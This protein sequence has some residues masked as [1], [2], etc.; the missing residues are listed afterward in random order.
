MYDCKNNLL[1][2]HH[3]GPYI[4]DA[5]YYRPYII[6]N[7]FTWDAVALIGRCLS[8]E[9][10]KRKSGTLPLLLLASLMPTFTSTIMYHQ[11]F[12]SKVLWLNCLKALNNS[13]P[14]IL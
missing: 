6:Y 3:F 10:A 8:R 13:T 7:L 5:C 1:P 14:L 2:T 12:N 4:E 9:D 11:T